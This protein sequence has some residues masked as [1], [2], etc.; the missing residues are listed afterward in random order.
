MQRG[1]GR[2][3]MRT[4]E[5]F[6]YKQNCSYVILVSESKREPSHAFYEWIGYSADQRGFK[7]RLL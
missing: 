1:A 2:L 3:L 6:G 7:K 5:E 4:L